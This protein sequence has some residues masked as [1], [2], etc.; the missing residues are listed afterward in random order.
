MNQTI[1][2]KETKKL[3]AQVTP[4]RTLNDLVRI[5]FGGELIED[6]NSI[7]IIRK[8]SIRNDQEKQ[9]NNCCHNWCPVA[10]S[11]SKDHVHGKN[12][13][14]W[15]NYSCCLCGEFKRRYLK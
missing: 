14:K 12:G 3:R 13:K 11:N 6:K 5:R 4:N 1:G 15:M 10:T 9:E 2:P 8:N 7:I